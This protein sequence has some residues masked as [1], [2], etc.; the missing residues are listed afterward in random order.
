M[1]D[2]LKGEAKE[3]GKALAKLAVKAC[4]H[5]VLLESLGVVAGGETTVTVKGKGVGGRNQ[6]LA[7][8]AALNLK[9]SRNA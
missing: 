9:E 8:S 7:L 4:L 3:V 1:A 6:E 2:L 5:A